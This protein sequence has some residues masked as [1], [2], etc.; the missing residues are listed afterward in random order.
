[1]ILTPELRAMLATPMGRLLPN[2]SITRDIIPDVQTL[3]TVGDA[4]TQKIIEMG[5]TPDV[6]LIDC[7]E[8]RHDR[9]APPGQ[10]ATELSCTNPAGHIT[11]SAVSAIRRAFESRR[12]VR[13]VVSGEEDLLALP[14]CMYAPLGSVLI[15]GQPGKGMVIVDI[16]DQARHRSK[17]LY[18]RLKGGNGGTGAV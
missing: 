11:D 17:S 7:R 12:P 15:Y 14:A 6:Q 4:T 18:M 13:I 9:L 1:M 16:D 8:R 5:I 2:D 3:I 10:Y